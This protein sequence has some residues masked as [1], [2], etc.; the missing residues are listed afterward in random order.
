MKGILFIEAINVSIKTCITSL[1]AK[2]SLKLSHTM[3]FINLS[4][5]IIKEKATILFQVFKWSTKG[6]LCN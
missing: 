1:V 6:F 2:R 4:K 3:V 5:S